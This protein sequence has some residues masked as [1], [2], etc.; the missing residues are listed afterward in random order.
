VK[1][2]RPPTKSHRAI[3]W[4]PILKKQG[5]LFNSLHQIALAEIYEKVYTPAKKTPGNSSGL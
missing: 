5:P 1:L 2:H 3:R 4:T